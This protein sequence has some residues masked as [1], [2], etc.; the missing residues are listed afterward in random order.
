MGILKSKK[1]QI[2]VGLLLVKKAVVTSRAQTYL[3][4]VIS[5]HA[6]LFIHRGHFVKLGLKAPLNVYF[7]GKIKFAILSYTYPIVHIKYKI[8]VQSKYKEAKIK[9]GYGL[10]G[11]QRG[12][13]RAR[14]YK[15]SME[16][17]CFISE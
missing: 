9:T 17:K 11:I 14:G 8:K 7:S 13:N 4:Y 16:I 6:R 10:K 12:R 15:W 2:L 5:F 1:V 3:K